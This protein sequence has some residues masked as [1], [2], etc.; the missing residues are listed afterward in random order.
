MAF[1]FKMFPE[2]IY[3]GRLY[4]AEPPLYRIDDKKDPFVINKAD[5]VNRYVKLASKNYKIGYQDIKKPLDIKWLDKEQWK[6]FLSDTSKYV[7]TIAKLAKRAKVNDRLLEMILEEYA[8][9]AKLSL[10]NVHER[11]NIQHMMNRIGEEFNEIFY[12]DTNNLIEGSIDGTWQSIEFSPY[13][14]K[15]SISIINIMIKWLP[16]E[17]GAIILRD[18]KTNTDHKLSLLGT[19]KI[20]KKYQPDILHRFKGLGENNYDDLKTTIMDPNTRT[21]IKLQISDF[22]NDMKIFQ[23]LRGGSTVDA[24]NRKTMMNAFNIDRDDI[25]T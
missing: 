1:F 2:I 15:K 14:F 21:L 23:M 25:D 6:E 11:I 8:L 24:L 5:Y 4:I 16:T 10:D 12:D 9:V 19:L 22:E 13:L 7:D 18:T 20:L 17:R 3:D